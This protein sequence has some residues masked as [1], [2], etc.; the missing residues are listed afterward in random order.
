VCLKAAAE[1]VSG[2]LSAGKESNAAELLA[3]A[4]VLFKA[5]PTDA[6][7][8]Q[9]NGA[10]EEKTPAPASSLN[11]AV[12]SEVAGGGLVEEHDEAF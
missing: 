6:N 10:G 5:S 9:D 12:D 8:G 7:T 2:G 3:Y 4:R 11:A 1:V